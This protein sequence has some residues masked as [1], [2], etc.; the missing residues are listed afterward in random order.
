M[1][2]KPAAINDTLLPIVTSVQHLLAETA[3]KGQKTVVPP[4]QPAAQTDTMEFAQRVVQ[5]F[6][7]TQGEALR[8]GVEP[9]DVSDAL[10]KLLMEEDSQ[11][12]V[13]RNQWTDL[14][15]A[16]R[17]AGVR[18]G[19]ALEALHDTVRTLG[20]GYRPTLVELAASLRA[21]IAKAGGCDKMSPQLLEQLIQS[22]AL[23]PWQATLVR[24]WMARRKGAGAA[25]LTDEDLEA[26][27]L[28]SAALE[29]LAEAGGGPWDAYVAQAAA[30]R[31]HRHMGEALDHLAP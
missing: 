20:L 7:A 17:Q 12:R 2:I 27:F 6:L 10:L 24:L 8:R 15:N 1:T 9:G 19:A 21:V 30:L 5:R 31:A 3:A 29:E 16:V 11:R 26:L 13:A 23:T 14:R 18:L 4:P 28:D 25:P 22:G